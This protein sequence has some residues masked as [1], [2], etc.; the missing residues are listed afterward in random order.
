M[1][2]LTRLIIVSITLVTLTSCDYTDFE[3]TWADPSARPIN[4]RTA[5][6]AVLLLS[7]NES[8]RRSF[9]YNLARQLNKHGVESTPGYELL[10]EADVTDKK[11]ILSELK[12]TGVDHAVFMRVI[13]RQL[14]LNYVPGSA[15]YPGFYYDPFF[16]SGGVFVG[17]WYDGL[18]PPYHDSSYY[19]LDEIVSVETLVYSI[20]DSKLVWTALSKTMNPEKVDDFVEELVEGA[21]KQM[22]KTG[23]FPTT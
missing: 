2:Y 7:A 17:P 4:P 6:V 21:V 3:S 10:A 19:R 15:W 20:P 8:V 16:W 13:D 5:H 14:E 22:R 18:W 23:I 11:E 9:E 1:T 12:Q